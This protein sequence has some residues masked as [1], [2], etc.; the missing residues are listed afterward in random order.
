[1]GYCSKEIQ[2]TE[3]HCTQKE[4][5]LQLHQLKREKEVTEQPDINDKWNT[6]IKDTKML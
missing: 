2:I 1:M 6:I 4:Q 5:Q 3:K